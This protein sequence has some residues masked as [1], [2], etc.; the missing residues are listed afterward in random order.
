ME[1]TDAKIDMLKLDLKDAMISLENYEVRISSFIGILSNF[2]VEKESK[3]LLGEHLSSL[4]RQT[5]Q[6]TEFTSLKEVFNHSAQLFSPVKEKINQYVA[7]IN[8]KIENNASL[9]ETQLVNSMKV[10]TEHCIACNDFG[11]K[12][13]I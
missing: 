4:L 3:I 9:N 6:D 11:M 1:E 8:E 13:R 5:C 12:L 10:L 7:V 2:Q